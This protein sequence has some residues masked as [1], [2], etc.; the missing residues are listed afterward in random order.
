MKDLTNVIIAFLLTLVFMTI[1]SLLGHHHDP[2][3]TIILYFTI[4]SCDT[5]R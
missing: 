4:L 2:F 3:L 5:Q 1:N